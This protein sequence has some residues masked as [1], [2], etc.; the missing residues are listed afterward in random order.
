METSSQLR[1]VQLLELEALT[2]LREFCKKNGMDFFLRGG[3]VMG[4][5]KYNGFVPWDDDVDIAVPRKYFDKLIE[6][7]SSHEWSDKFYLLS[8]KYNPEIHCYFPR[9]LVKENIRKEMG[10][11][12]NNKLGLTVIDVLPLDGAPNTRVERELYYIL[13]YVCRALAGVWTMDIKETVDM[14]D[15]KKRAILKI[16]KAIR[17]NKLYTQTEMYNRLDALYRSHSLESSS[18]AGTI[19]GSLYKKE[20]VRKEWWGKGIE[21]KFENQTFLVPEK[22]DEYLKKLYG[23][24]YMTYTPDADQQEAKKHIK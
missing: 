13:V 14:H 23:D 10:L 19:T 1:K 17:I 21:M 16:L 18:Y 11:P 12:S 24:N 15:A 22:Y 3:S 7:T 5:V 6:L 4:A 9:V 8:Y 2:E 20:I